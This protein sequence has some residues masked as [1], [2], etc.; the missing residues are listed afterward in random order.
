M[1]T[2]SPRSP[3]AKFS[4]KLH[5]LILALPLVAGPVL[6]AQSTWL[7]N[8][9]GNTTWTTAA[10]DPAL[11]VSGTSTVVNFFSSNTTV[12][13]GTLIAFNDISPMV[14]NQLN[15][16][17]VGGSS[18]GALTLQGGGI[19]FGGTT[20]QL[21]INPVYGAGAGYTFNLATPLTFNAPTTITLGNGG[22]FINTTSASTWTGAGNVTLIGSFTNRPLSLGGA[23]SGF[24]GDLTLSGNSTVLQL[25]FVT[26][27]LGSGTASQAVV[28]GA[29]SGINMVYNSNAATNNQTFVVNGNG[30]SGTSNASINVT[31]VGNG[32]NPIGAL[33]VATNSTIRIDQSTEVSR[34][35]GTL[36]TRGLLGTGD[37]TKTGDGYLYINAASSNA[38]LVA[39]ATYDRFSGNITINQGAIATPANTSNSIGSITTQTVLVTNGAAFAHVSGDNAYVNPQNFVLNG[40]GTG[41]IAT[42]GGYGAYSTGAAGFGNNRAG[43]LSIQSDS[44]VAVNR[45]SSRGNAGFQLDRGL[46]GSGTLNI[47]NLYGNTVGPMYIGNATTSNVT[48]TAGVFERFSGKVVINN[49]ILITTG[50]GALGDSTNGQIFLSGLG[51]FGSNGIAL[52]PVNQSYLDRISNLATTSGT[53]LLAA[54]NPN[55]LDFTSAPNLRLGSISNSNSS[56]GSGFTYSGTLTPGSN[57]YRL[58][59]TGGGILTV[60]SNLTGTNS[61]NV[62]GSVT[63]TGAGNTFNGGIT[64]AGL[65]TNSEFAARLNYTNGTGVLP[66]SN[67]LTFAGTGGTLAYA[68]PINTT[69][70]S[71]SLGNLTFSE[72]LGS[73]TATTGNATVFGTSTLTFASLTRAA[74]AAGTLQ[75][76][77]GTNGTT[78]KIVIS[79]L[80]TTAGIVSKGVFFNSGNY[81]F[82]D[83]AGFLRAP[84]YGTDA[85]FVTSGTTATVA[86]AIHQQI[87]GNITAQETANFNTLRLSGNAPLNIPS[88]QIVTTDGILKAGGTAVTIAGPGVIRAS[89]G[90]EMVVNS[91]DALTISASI[92]DN[93]GSS[94]TKVGAGSLT[95]SGLITDYSG[96]TTI[97]QGTFVI[98]STAGISSTGPIS[99]T[100]GTL[101]L[102]GNKT[103]GEVTLKNGLIT[104]SILTPS[105]AN[106]QN[107]GVHAVIAGSGNVTK[108]TEGYV[109]LSA[110]NTYSGGTT[111]NAG[112]IGLI[113]FGSFGTGPLTISGGRVDLGGKTITNTLGPITGGGSLH[114]GRIVNDG[115]TYQL[116]N[117]VITAVLAGT[118]GLNKTSNGTLTLSANN[119]YTGPTT[120]SEGS[121]VL[122]AASLPGGGLGVSKVVLSSGTTLDVSGVTASTVTLS[123]GLGGNGTVNATGKNL[124]VAGT[125][126]PG[127]MSI[128]GNLTFDPATLTTF[129]ASTT[130]GVSTALTVTGSVTNSGNLT[131]SPAPSFTFA[132]NQTFTFV[133]A[134]D[135]ITP[136]YSGVTANGV[137]LTESPADIWSATDSGLIYTYTENTATLTVASAVVYSP[138]QLWRNDK[139]GTYDNTGSAADTFDADG[140]GISN[141]MEYALNGNPNAAD[142]SILPQITGTGPLKLT[143][144]RNGDANIT[145]IVEARDDLTTGSWVEKYNSFGTTYTPGLFEVTDSGQ[146]GTKRFMRLRVTIP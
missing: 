43:S 84:V 117:G 128:T 60:S 144:Y 129:V 16:S 28:V 135:G 108:T 35:D 44:T 113:G 89:A 127:A 65:H 72:G 6:H 69:E 131:I 52:N 141:L 130:P 78:N 54:A 85:D 81:A 51:G 82:N 33:A 70:T 55:N 57:G 79:S 45:S 24:T 97:A 101:Q 137:A 74:G 13:A 34:A 71:Q 73:V 142:A 39:G 4:A 92:V 61:L 134:S 40:A 67:N 126:T 8:A 94:L 103:V 23:A 14:V 100:G 10:W 88:G 12:G 49:G 48:T 123:G 18:A 110:N 140:D 145:Y 46:F 11:P 53:L 42:L 124:L 102:N 91:V 47:T 87:T 68:T 93:V 121:L 63:L 56:A 21:N 64:I 77:N 138:L 136:G 5:S 99:I 111:V 95:L 132:G 105:G 58:G 106:L 120:L 25:N 19:T 15:I 109:Y 122:G 98:G 75:T 90:T 37:L 31:G 133:S 83:A 59:G 62:G 2:S 17:G 104:G 26:N 118:N 27:T 146:V 115:G 3:R 119:T 112:S 125:F 30:N 80:G 116:Q 29:G 107:G 86:S 9:A 1:T 7:T 139:F 114:N 143:F 76:V 96:G 32:N 66:S 50:S 41:Y 38:T 20:P 22:G 36:L